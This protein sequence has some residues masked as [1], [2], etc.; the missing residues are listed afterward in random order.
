M[1]LSARREWRSAIA[2]AET[3][4]AEDR[5]QREGLRRHRLLEHFHRAERGGFA[6]I[7]RA[8]QLSPRDPAAPTWHFFACYLRLTLAEWESAVQSCNRSLAG[9][10]NGW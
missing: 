7:E 10:P 1:V 9:Q 4:I 8:F 2:E 3:A 6:D 5:Q